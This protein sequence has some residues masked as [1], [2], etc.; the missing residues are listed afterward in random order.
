MSTTDP[1]SLP[2]HT[3]TDSDLDQYEGFP[4]DDDV[5]GI[6]DRYSWV[7]LAVPGALGVWDGIDLGIGTL[8]RPGGGLWMV[9]L[10]S[11]LLVF[12][13][14][15]AVQGHRFQP[16]RRVGLRRIAFVAGGLIAFPV[17]YTV[18]GFVIAGAVMLL[19]ISRFAA[20]ESWRSALLVSVLAPLVVYAA[21]ALALGV[22]LRF[23]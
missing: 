15:I 19:L 7:L 8:D 18:A 12:S 23:I 5:S 10:G 2:T 11:L 9:I 13:A 14:V 21:F 4:L 3:G 22:N 17:L 16:P 20:Q 1:T 6:R